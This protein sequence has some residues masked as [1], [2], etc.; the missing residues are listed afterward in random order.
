MRHDDMS[1]G[2]ECLISWC[3]VGIIE[4]CRVDLIVRQPMHPAPVGAGLIFRDAARSIVAHGVR[5]SMPISNAARRYHDP[6]DDRDFEPAEQADRID[7]DFPIVEP[8]VDPLDGW[9]LEKLSRIVK[10]DA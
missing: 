3:H 2:P 5:S 9:A 8:V 4:Y 6:V 10:R 1:I 7:A